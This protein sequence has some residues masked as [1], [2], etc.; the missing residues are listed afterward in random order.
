M[1]RDKGGEEAISSSCLLGKLTHILHILHIQGKFYYAAQVAGD[2]RGQ[3][4]YS[5]DL[6]ASSSAMC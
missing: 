3:V 2:R 5:L 4:S 6:R 1:T